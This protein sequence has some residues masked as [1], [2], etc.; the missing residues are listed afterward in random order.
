MQ[1]TDPHQRKQ[2]GGRRNGH[3]KDNDDITAV[4]EHHS[5]KAKEADGTRWSLSVRFSFTL[6]SDPQMAATDRSS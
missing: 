5:M 2:T 1:I 3:L 4:T 6:S